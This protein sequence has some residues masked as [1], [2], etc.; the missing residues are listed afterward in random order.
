MGFTVY[1]EGYEALNRLSR[2]TPQPEISKHLA[3]V[4]GPALVRRAKKLAGQEWTVQGYE[5]RNDRE[6]IWALT[7]SGSKGGELEIFFCD[8]WSSQ[9][10]A[11]TLACKGKVLRLELAKDNAPWEAYADPASPLPGEEWLLGLH[12]KDAYG[13][14]YSFT[15]EAAGNKGG[16]YWM[17]WKAA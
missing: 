15:A 13:S 8:Y 17:V 6:G 12:E 5:S 14:T 9:N 10:P 16:R 4:H 2:W 11:Y 3:Q 1:R 7:L